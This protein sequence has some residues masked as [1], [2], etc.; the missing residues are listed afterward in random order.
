[1]KT[2]KVSEATNIQLDWLVA[3]CEG[4]YKGWPLKD[5]LEQRKFDTSWRYT[6]DPAQ[7]WPIIERM[8]EEG[9]SLGE[10]PETQ[11]HARVGYKPMA[12]EYKFFGNGETMLIAAARCY[13]VSRLGETVE[14]PEEL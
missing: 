1:M 10:K 2:I 13:V 8:A 4:A 3:K 7:M 11:A 6:T 12:G 9:F 5:W 14:V